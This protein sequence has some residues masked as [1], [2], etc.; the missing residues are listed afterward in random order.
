M[1]KGAYYFVFAKLNGAFVCLGEALSTLI[2]V[3]DSSNKAVRTEHVLNGIQIG[4]DFRGTF[5]NSATAGTTVHVPLL[6]PDNPLAYYHVGIMNPLVDS[7]LTCEIMNV[8][9]S[10]ASAS[11]HLSLGSWTVP[12]HVTGAIKDGSIQ[13]LYDLFNGSPVP[14]TTTMVCDVTSGSNSVTTASTANRTVGELV[15]GTGIPDN[16]VIKSITNGTTFTLGNMAGTDVNA[17]A[18]N[19]GTTLTFST[20][21]AVLEIKLVSNL[22]SSGGGSVAGRIL[23]A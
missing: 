10:L 5:A 17:T 19:A 16:T 22:G 20:I 13:T 21:A 3:F 12:K 9:P 8:A 15:T 18:T 6:K 7:D 11:Q 23:G 14:A 2:E 4:S 1:L